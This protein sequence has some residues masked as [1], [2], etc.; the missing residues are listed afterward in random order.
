MAVVLQC[1][2]NA[3]PLHPFDQARR[4]PRPSLFPT[5]PHKRLRI[6][7]SLPHVP[8]KKPATLASRSI[9]E[10]EA[11][12]FAAAFNRDRM[13]CASN[14]ASRAFQCN[15]EFALNCNLRPN[16]CR[17]SLQIGVRRTRLPRE[18]CFVNRSTPWSSLWAVS[19]QGV[20]RRTTKRRAKC[21]AATNPLMPAKQEENVRASKSPALRQSSHS[22]WGFRSVF[23]GT[24]QT[25]R[26][27][28][29]SAFKEDSICAV[30]RSSTRSH[31]RDQIG[32]PSLN[33]SRDLLGPFRL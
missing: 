4:G 26:T 19:S 20:Q 21:R 30:L 7:L 22:Q 15:D 16:I 31:V 24:F 8:L 28:N 14:M 6:T 5:R 17:V 2:A 9:L 11:P 32:M 10:N 29:P 25:S 23:A 27:F 3:P 1:V 13:L 12:K 18:L 33:M